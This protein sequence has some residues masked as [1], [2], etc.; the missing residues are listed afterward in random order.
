MNNNNIS[1]GGPKLLF[2]KL[3]DI[4]EEDPY[5]NLDH[6]H[7]QYAS[8]NFSLGNRIGNLGIMIADDELKGL[9][10]FGHKGANF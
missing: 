10:D 7:T 1:K 5:S 2:H 3:E 6:H 4:L 9:S 8:D